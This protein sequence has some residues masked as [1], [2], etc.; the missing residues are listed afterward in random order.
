MKTQI[1]AH[2]GRVGI[3]AGDKFVNDPMGVGQLGCIVDLNEIV[4]SAAAL[5]ILRGVKKNRDAIGDVMCWS[6]NAPNRKDG[7]RIDCFGWMGGGK[8]LLH[9]DAEADRDYNPALL[10]RCIGAVPVPDEFRALVEL[11]GKV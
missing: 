11:D 7:S 2:K 8:Y 1:F 3:V 5:A 9:K 10:E 4:V 6:A